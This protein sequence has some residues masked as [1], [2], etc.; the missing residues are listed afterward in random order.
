[1]KSKSIQMVAVAGILIVLA[2]YFSIF[3]PLNRQE[4]P[5]AE[6]MIKSTEYIASPVSYN[7]YEPFEIQ[8]PDARDFAYN[9][10]IIYVLFSNKI[11]IFDRT[12]QEIGSINLS[13]LNPPLINADRFTVCGNK[14]YIGDSGN[15][16]IIVYNVA[17]NST[18]L[19]DAH[20]SFDDT[21]VSFSSV[22]RNNNKVLFSTESGMDTNAFI[23]TE[24][25][26]SIAKAIKKRWGI[27]I[28]RNETALFVEQMRYFKEE[29]RYGY[30]AGYNNVLEYST[31]TGRTR[32]LFSLPYNYDVKDG[33]ATAEFLC[34]YS[35]SNNTLDFFTYNGE[36]YSSIYRGK[37]DAIEPGNN[38]DE[39]Y[40]LYD[41]IIRKLSA[42]SL[43]GI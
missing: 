11:K 29:S 7:V 4:L 18:H 41:G 30:T 28:D 26:M 3:Q 10:G 13:L 35:S 42:P 43:G 20:R 17:E 16:G 27:W 2:A 1:M 40:I 23:L 36:H 8:V 14:I 33:F 22:I 25:N 5:S 21:R 38:I 37:V 19:I 24:K 6:L 31:R 39:L 32:T 9:D 34:L 15:L 12:A